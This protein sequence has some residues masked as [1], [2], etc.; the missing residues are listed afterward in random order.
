MVEKQRKKEL[1]LFD[2]PRNRKIVILSLYI[3]LLILLAVDLVI[4]RHGD[5]PW[6]TAPEFFAVYGFVA[7]VVLVFAAKVLRFVVE[8]KEDYYD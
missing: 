8:R 4:H 7:C 3:A 6:E 2:K 5:F 1:T